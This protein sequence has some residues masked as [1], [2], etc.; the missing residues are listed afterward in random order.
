MIVKKS[1]TQKHFSLLQACIWTSASQILLGFIMWGIIKKQ[2]PLVNIA[3]IEI[4]I[5]FLISALFGVYGM[6]K[7]NHWLIWIYKLQVGVCIAVTLLILMDLIDVLP[8]FPVELDFEKFSYLPRFGMKTNEK[9]I[10]DNVDVL[11]S[12]PNH[13]DKNEEIN[14]FSSSPQLSFLQKISNNSMS[15][16]TK[17]LENKKRLGIEHEISPH[18]TIQRED[19]SD[20]ELSKLEWA[21]MRR[22]SH[23]LER[24]GEADEVS[25]AELPPEVYG[26]PRELQ[27]EVSATTK[28]IKHVIKFAFSG[29]FALICVFQIYCSYIVFTFILNKC[30]SV[31]EL[32]HH[33]EQFEPIV[34]IDS[35][36]TRFSDNIPES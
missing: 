21:D 17:P 7:R 19:I 3:H 16:I 27:Q 20:E 13:L 1:Y 4:L 24:E 12:F 14:V 22:P 5:S 28:V 9:K 31:D 15:I 34:H 11:R 33:P 35:F 26:L 2:R 6:Y 30:T 32:I 10:D 36:S 25:K 8:L 23:G 29:A 18:H